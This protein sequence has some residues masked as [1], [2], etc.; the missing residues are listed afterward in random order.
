MALLNRFLKGKA[1]RE[2]PEAAPVDAPA[3]EPGLSRADPEELKKLE[4]YLVKT[5]KLDP[6]GED[7]QPELQTGP[8]TGPPE[9]SPGYSS[10]L[11]DDLDAL[12]IT[13]P[14]NKSGGDDGTPTLQLDMLDVFEDEAA[15]DEY[16]DALTSHVEEVDARELVEELN[17]FMDE[18][19]S[20]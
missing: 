14:E 3:P 11:L 9:T 7:P 17:Y 12:E 8:G 2:E 4:G 20:R 19:Q 1:G 5:I 13:E 6:E 15:G 10:G 18:L 16:L